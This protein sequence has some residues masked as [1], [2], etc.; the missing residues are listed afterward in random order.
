MREF[1]EKCGLRYHFFLDGI[2]CLCEST[3]KEA[4]RVASERFATHK[5]SAS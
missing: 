2:I 4:D 1:M 5:V 3:I